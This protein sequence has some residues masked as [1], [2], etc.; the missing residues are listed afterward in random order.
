MPKLAIIGKLEIA[1]GH[2]DRVLP[3]LMAH[4]A[5]CLADE[6]GTLQFEV[7]TRRKCCCTNFT[8][9]TRRSRSI[10][11]DLQR[12]VCGKRLGDNCGRHRYKVRPC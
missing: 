9:T 7:L 1:P 12:P 11:T 5:R 3:L 4:R 8:Q 6:P 2:L 10:G